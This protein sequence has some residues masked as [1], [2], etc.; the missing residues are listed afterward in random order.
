[1]DEVVTGLHAVTVHITDL[2]KA[3]RFYSEVLGFKELSAEEK[4][5]RAVFALPDTTTLLTMHIQGP[6]EGGREPGTVTGII[7]QHPDP[8]AACDEI[9][10]RG[11]TIVNEPRLVERPG[12]R[13]VLAAI[14]DPD[15]NEFVISDRKD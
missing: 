11:G 12:H 15:G 8:T 4:V 14:A 3:R 13:F 7:F 5:G 6:G 9:K 1:M 2:A 10:R